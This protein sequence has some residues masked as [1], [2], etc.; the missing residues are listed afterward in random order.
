MIWSF[1]KIL[2]FL[3]LAAAVTFGASYMIDAG[4]EVRIA[5][6]GQEISLTPLM[7][8]IIVVTA[9]VALLLLLKL[10]GFLLAILRFVNGDETAMSRYFDKNRERKGFEA[11]SES[12][13]ALAA[14]DGKTAMSKATRA[15]KFLDRPELTQLVNAQAADV[16]GNKERAEEHFKALLKDERTRFVG[17]QGLMKQKLADGD[18]D[19]AM[20]L[21]KKA[22]AINPTHSGTM[23]TLFQLQTDKSDWAGARDTLQARVRRRALPKDIG[24]R[25]DAV[26][27]LAYAQAEQADG[28]TEN[29]MESVLKANKGAPGL[30]PAAVLLAQLQTQAGDQR[31]ATNVIK[32]AWSQNPHPDL[33]AAFAAIQPDETS[34]ERLNR[35]KALLKVKPDHAETRMLEAELYLADED[36]PAA[37]KAIG[38]L[39]ETNPTARSLA[40]MAAVERG[41]GADEAAVSGWLA[42][43][44]SAPR[45]DT[46]V[47]GSCRHT[48]N[49]WAPVCENCGGFDTIAWDKGPQNEDSKTMAAAML[50]LIIGDKIEKAEQDAADETFVDGASSVVDDVAE[51]LVEDAQKAAS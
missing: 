43:A 51:D 1:V 6:G 34:Q 37:R 23:E 41:S 20:A 18:T 7:A 35:F 50:P 10:A 38:D 5:F 33:A 29:A 39:A 40:I 2:I 21:A 24:K 15:E 48:H 26:L 25:R 31:K 16:S 4:G 11:L 17:V 47:C 8:T 45:G 42:K 3:G 28:D 32:K 12:I 46:W 27:S 49:D 22:F 19:T 14:G 36:F 13:I 30:V 44:I 9:F